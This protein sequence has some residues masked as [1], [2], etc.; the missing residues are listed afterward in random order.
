MTFQA[1]TREIGITPSSLPQ[2]LDR[3]LA[4]SAIIR[5]QKGIYALP[6]SAPV[7]VPASD[8]IISGLSKKG[9]KLGPLVQ[10]V[11]KTTKSTRSR[12][13]ITGVLS[14]LKKEGTVKQ[15]RR[16]GEYRLARRLRLLRSGESARGKAPW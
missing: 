13:T 16:Y 4:K 6:G 10:Y 7:Y 12:G 2:F 15:E 9:M 1:L 11:N 3:L 5:T 8:A 14:R